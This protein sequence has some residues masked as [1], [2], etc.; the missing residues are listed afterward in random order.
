MTNPVQSRTLL[1]LRVGIG[2]ALLALTIAAGLPL[3]Q[4]LSTNAFVN[5]ETAPVH[6]LDLDPSGTRLAVA[7]LPD[8]RIEIF[9]VSGLIPRPVLSVPVGLDPVSVRWRTTGE[10]WVVAQIA[11]AVDIIEIPSGRIIGQIP[12]SD[13]PADVVFAGNPVRA[14]VSS[15]GN[16]RLEVFDPVTRERTSAIDLLG[17]RPKALAITA[18]GLEVCVAISESGNATTILAP[19]MDQVGHRQG[20][21]VADLPFGPNLGQNPAPNAPGSNTGFLP[22]L[23]PSLTHLPP[24]VPLI[25]RK[26]TDAR[27]RDGEGKDWSEFVSGTNAAFSGRLPGWDL[28]DHDVALVNTETLAVRYANGLMN[29]CSALAVNPVSGVIAVVGMDARNEVRFAVMR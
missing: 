20:G 11:D 7:N 29:Q 17:H 3:A 16:D 19:F 18:N 21:G 10:L 24:S 8:A 13:A 22:P 1:S 6:P 28:P 4:A 26:G 25:V 14:F 2:P 12:T 9:D 23:N 15:A 5:F 27:W